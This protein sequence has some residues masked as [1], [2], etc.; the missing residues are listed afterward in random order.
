LGGSPSRFVIQALLEYL[1]VISDQL[2][3]P[4]D[5]PVLER[6]TDRLFRPA[7]KRLGWDPKPGEGDEERLSRSA[8]LWAMGALAQDEDILSELP[9][10]LTQFWT[11]P[12][13]MDATLLGTF[14]RLCIRTD[15]GSL[16]EKFV[17]KTT[18]APTPEDRDRYLIALA[19]YK[20]PSLARKVLEF[21]ISP[22]IRAQDAW[23]PIRY[24]EGNIPVQEETWS[25]IQER[26]RDIREKTGT[27]GTQRIIQGLRSFWKPEWRSGVETFFG[28]AE[29]HIPAAERA[30]AQTLE[31]MDIGIRFRE[32]QAEDLSQWFKRNPNP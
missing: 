24:M 32:M 17:R 16:F 3:R 20:K 25:F 26:W 7:W 1:E 19:E 5:R 12:A 4:D 29:N 18:L 21:A 23:R 11:D 14:L 31:F 8:A 27:V 9:R 15:G 13:A 28:Q 6:F 30:L 22:D 2:V 10:L